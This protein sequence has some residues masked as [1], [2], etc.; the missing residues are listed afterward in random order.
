MTQ[1]TQVILGAAGSGASG[2]S[3][4]RARL[5]A[6]EGTLCQDR[7]GDISLP[8][9][10]YTDGIFSLWENALEVMMSAI[11][12]S[13]MKITALQLVGLNLIITASVLQR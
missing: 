9:Q 6:A 11:T 10:V 12:L 5:W 3:T 1:C 8:S 13:C 7:G 2:S 4:I